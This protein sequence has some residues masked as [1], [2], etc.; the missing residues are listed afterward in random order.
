[1]FEFDSPEA[2][3]SENLLSR[4][5]NPEDRVAFLDELKKTGKVNNFELDT[6][7]KTGKTIACNSELNS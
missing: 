3:M 6:I 4:Y 7:S 2:M 1:M 5:K